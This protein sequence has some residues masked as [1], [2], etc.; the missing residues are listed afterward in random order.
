[1]ILGVYVGLVECTPSG[2][3]SRFAGAPVCR[4]GRAL[5]IHL[6]SRLECTLSRF[7][8]SYD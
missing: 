1:M 7:K 6:K 2:G 4:G 5:Y 3:H 8:K